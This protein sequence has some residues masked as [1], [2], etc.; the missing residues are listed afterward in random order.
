ML[1]MLRKASLPMHTE[2][3]IAEATQI[4]L[5][6]IFAAPAANSYVYVR[7]DVDFRDEE[8]EAVVPWLVFGNTLCN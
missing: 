1:I 4:V 2:S 8:A 5:R 6:G 3:H 7:V